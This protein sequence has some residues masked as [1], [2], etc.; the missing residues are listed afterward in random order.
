MHERV[1]I[2][3]FGFEHGFRASHLGFAKA[4]NLPSLAP[5]KMCQLFKSGFDVQMTKTKQSSIVSQRSME[6]FALRKV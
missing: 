4:K 6:H 2:C 1:S 3:H 5:S